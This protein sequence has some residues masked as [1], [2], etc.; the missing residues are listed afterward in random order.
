MDLQLIKSK[1]DEDGVVIIDSVFDKTS[2]NSLNEIASSIPPFVGTC[3]TRGWLDNYAVEKI[4]NEGIEIDWAYNWSQIPKDNQFINEVLFPTLNKIADSLFED[5]D[6][7]WQTTNLYIVSNYPHDEL[8]YPHFDAP[9]LW[10]QRLDVQ[11]A[12]Y[13]D[14]GVLSV[15]FMIPLIEFTIENGATAFV[16]GTHK[17]VHDTLDWEES[18]EHRQRFFL[19]NYIQPSVP[20]GSLSCFYGNCLHS[21]MQNKSKEIR[22]AVIIRAIR[23]DALDEMDR[24]D[25]G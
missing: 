3:K 4:L 25:L 14:K 15:T 19:D 11:M 21:I 23:K 9:Y 20:L 24:L 7:G 18:K 16:R 10:P 2:L 17:Y 8:V 13:L 6:W 5:K 22:R 12:K 1:L